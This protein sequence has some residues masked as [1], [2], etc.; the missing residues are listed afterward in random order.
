MMMA[1]LGQTVL[2]SHLVLTIGRIGGLA[3]PPF[4]HLGHRP[5]YTASHLLMGIALVTVGW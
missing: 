3:G 1:K 5:S 4:R 2:V